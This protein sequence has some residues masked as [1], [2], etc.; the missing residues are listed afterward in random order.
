[1]PTTAAVPTTAAKTRLTTRCTSD[2]GVSMVPKHPQD[3]MSVPA[4][5]AAST[6]PAK[7]T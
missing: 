5:R 2:G 6:K 7:A 1:M 3:W 4:R